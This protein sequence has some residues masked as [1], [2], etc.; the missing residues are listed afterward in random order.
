MKKFKLHSFRPGEAGVRKVLGDLEA[1]IME[2][3]WQKDTCSVREI[4]ECLAENRDIAYTTVMTVMSRLADKGILE[5]DR[6]G[7]HFLYKPAITK[8]EFRLMMFSSVVGGLKAD[9]GKQA[10]AFFV[11]S[12]AEGEDTLDELEQL[13]REKRRQS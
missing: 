4:H 9:L 2:I 7:K 3:V 8:D 12:L 5:K 11:D 13:I 1:D 10:L 6:D